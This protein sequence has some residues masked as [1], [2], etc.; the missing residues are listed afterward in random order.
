MMNF[1]FSKYLVDID[2]FEMEKTPIGHGQF[3]VVYKALRQKDPKHPKRRPEMLCAVKQLKTDEIRSK[4]DQEK[5]HKEVGCQANLKHVG[6]LPL[7]G[8]TI[9]LMNKGMYTVITEFMPNG[10]LLKLIEKVASGNAPEDWETIKAI[11]IFGIAAAMAYVH[12]HSVIHRD[13]KTENIMLDKDYYPKIADFGLSKIFEEGTQD[14]I[15]QTLE[16]GTPTYMAPE[17]LEDP[18][19]TNKVDVFAYSIILYELITNNKPWSDKKN[20]TKFNLFKYVQQGERPTIHDREIPEDYVELIERCWDK[21][22]ENRP[23]FIRIV[24]GFMDNKDVYFDS[25]MIDQEALDDYIDEAVK[26]LDF[27]KVEVEVEDED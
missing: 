27:S 12:Q 3:G 1:F 13:L 26:D 17:L 16:V 9:P 19:Y 18:H 20:L 23:S 8:Y 5:F 15:N 2:S 7:V 11:N 24:K 4:E 22:P 25:P 14:H 10:S 21:E 6:V